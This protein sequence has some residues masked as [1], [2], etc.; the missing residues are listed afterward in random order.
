[1]NYSHPS[2]RY[3]KVKIDLQNLGYVGCGKMI[4]SHVPGA[5]GVGVLIAVTFLGWQNM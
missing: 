5:M 2:I 1:M 4:Y 3:A